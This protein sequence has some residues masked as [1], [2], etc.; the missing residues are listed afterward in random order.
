M[1]K[2]TSEVLPSGAQLVGPKHKD[3]F[4]LFVDEYS[5][6]TLSKEDIARM[7]GIAFPEKKHGCCKTK[8]EQ[9][10]EEVANE[11]SIESTETNDYF[12]NQL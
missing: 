3:D 7:Y 2:F 8:F 5:S 11:N 10:I 6:I 4:F 12:S 1:E 9:A